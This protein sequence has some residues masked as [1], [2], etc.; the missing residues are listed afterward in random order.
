MSVEIY[1]L[2]E[3]GC[4]VNSVHDAPEVGRRFT[5][6]ID[7][8]GQPSITVE[9]ATCYARP[10]GYAVQFVD[11]SENTKFQLKMAVARIQSGDPED[12]SSRI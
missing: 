6:R 2:S 7:V 9:A 11:L 1:D 5:L 8:P 3:G 10:G 4:F 12:E